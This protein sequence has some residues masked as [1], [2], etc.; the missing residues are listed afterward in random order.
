[1][2]VADYALPSRAE[3]LQQTMKGIVRD[4]GQVPVLEPYIR[5]QD[6][7]LL[8]E[9]EAKVQQPQ[10]LLE[11]EVVALLVLL[12]RCGGAVDTEHVARAL[13]AHLVDDVHPG[14]LVELSLRGAAAALKIMTELE[15]QVVSQL[16]EMIINTYVIYDISYPSQYELLQTARQTLRSVALMAQWK[17]GLDMW[18]LDEQDDIDLDDFDVE[19]TVMRVVDDESPDMLSEEVLPVM[20][21]TSPLRPAFDERRTAHETPRKTLTAPVP[22]APRRKDLRVITTA[23]EGSELIVGTFW[24]RTAKIGAPL[25]WEE[26][27]K[28]MALVQQVASLFQ[29][30]DPWVLNGKINRPAIVTDCHHSGVKCENWSQAMNLAMERL[31]TLVTADTVDVMKLYRRLHS[32]KLRG[33]APTTCSAQLYRRYGFH[34]EAGEKEE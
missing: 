34:S 10:Q 12:K 14:Q 15:P 28:G 30:N 20:P 6:H 8:A 25:N 19:R 33:L 11:T 4:E 21:V 2:A 27:S 9:A 22:P 18:G 29:V 3:Q 31:R 5:A 16:R 1:V 13:H 17:N 26:R 23:E 32:R 7:L 24:L